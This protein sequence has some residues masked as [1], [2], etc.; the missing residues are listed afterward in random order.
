[1]S[2]VATFEYDHR[3]KST[4]SYKLR[5]MAFPTSWKSSQYNDNL[6]GTGV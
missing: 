4:Y 5:D 3:Y 6:F 1:M 2:S